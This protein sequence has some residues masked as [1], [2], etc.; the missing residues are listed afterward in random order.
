M[1]MTN[2]QIEN[3]LRGLASFNTHYD[4]MK[5]EAFH[6]YGANDDA[7][8]HALPDL[9][10]ILALRQRV[11]ELETQVRSIALS[12]NELAATVERLK[13]KDISS[14]LCELRG[15]YDGDWSYSSIEEFALSWEQ[16]DD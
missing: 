7:T 15:N 13:N 8:I 4:N 14:F 10:E 2:E 5:K 12:R 11:D 16:S 6:L 3:M 1:K 9:R